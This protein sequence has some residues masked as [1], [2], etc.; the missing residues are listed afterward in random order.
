MDIKLFDVEEG[1][2]R[3]TEHCYNLPWLSKIMDEFPDQYM[4]VYGYLFYMSCRS[5]YNPYFNLPEEELEETVLEDIEAEFDIEDH[6]ILVALEKCRKMYETPT[7]R[8]YKGISKMLDKL[9]TYMETQSITDGRD[10]N[11]TQLIRA[12]KEF[13]SIRKSFKGTLRDLEE[14][15][16]SRTRGGS[17]MA[18]DQE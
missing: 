8:A 15:T 5:S 16:S 7:V 14:E 1:V 10:G 4:K 3:P 18:Y 6:T 17:S 9:A 12:A 11:I 2:V 13:D